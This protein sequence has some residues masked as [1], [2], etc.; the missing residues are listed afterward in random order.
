MSLQPTAASAVSRS[1][2]ARR[3]SGAFTRAATAGIAGTARAVGSVPARCLLLPLL[4][5]PLLPAPAA[6]VDT[7]NKIVLRVNDQVATLHDYQERREQAVKEV[8]R[9]EGDAAERMRQLSQIGEMVFRNMFEELLLNS[10]A[11]QLGI[12]A[13]DQQIAGEE[14][15]MRQSFGINTDQEFAAA[16][17]QSG[18]TEDELKQQLR[19]TLRER[20][21]M[22][23]ELQSRVKVKEEDL[24]H[25][26]REHQDQFKVPEQ[27]QLRE[28]VVL[29]DGGLPATG[30]EQA[31]SDISRQVAAGKSLADAVAPYAD[32]G[33]ASKVVDFG[34]VTPGDLDKAL[35][36]AVAQLAPGKLSEPVKARGGLHLLQVADRRPAHVQAFQEVQAAIQSHEQERLYQQ[37]A[38]KYLAELEQRSIVVADPPAE[39]A[40]FRRQLGGAND[41]LKP[42]AT[43]AAGSS[44]AGAAAAQGAPSPSDQIKAQVGPAT[45]PGGKPAPKKPGSLPTPHPVDPSPAGPP[46]TPPS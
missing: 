34:W 41:P 28:V 10:R 35:A 33:T 26:Y 5:L 3:G 24:R 14:S 8:M 13:T 21:V 20:Q 42:A 36:V 1:I 16:L 6:A 15:R 19:R 27:V 29:E 11:D 44:G 45:G 32:K 23:K 43:G 46:P 17:A 4:L 7:L 9:R 38:I 37:E 2:A 12:E 39:A 40:S 18:M 30:Q 25:Y 22:E 31:A